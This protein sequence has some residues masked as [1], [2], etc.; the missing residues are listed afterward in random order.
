MPETVIS[1]GSA[2]TL[3]E[4]WGRMIFESQDKTAYEICNDKSRW[5]NEHRSEMSKYDVAQYRRE[6]SNRIADS[7]QI[8]K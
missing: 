3:K 7:F 4:L 2:I 1:F 5:L 6:F 8:S